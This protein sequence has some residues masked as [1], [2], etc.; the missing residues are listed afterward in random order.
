ML[1]E[2]R[3][4]ARE[5]ADELRGVPRSYIRAMAAL[6]SG[7][8]CRCGRRTGLVANGAGSLTCS[9]CALEKRAHASATRTTSDMARRTAARR[10]VDA[11]KRKPV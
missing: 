8:P 4:G 11:A 6:R 7:R 9:I 10:A 5:C 1:D 2:L 3:S